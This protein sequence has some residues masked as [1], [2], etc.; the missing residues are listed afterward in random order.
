MKS[1]KTA[2]V[3]PMTEQRVVQLIRAHRSPSGGAG[4][5]VSWNRPVAI[6]V[7]PLAALGIRELSAALLWLFNNMGGGGGPVVDPTIPPCVSPV[8]TTYD[9]QGR[10]EQQTFGSPEIRTVVYSYDAAS[11]LVQKVQTYNGLTRTHTYTYD[12]DNR[13][14]NES[15]VTA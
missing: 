7:P 5:P 3:A 10:I 1:E 6:G 8:A 13:L 11:N 2:D 9:A 14:T 12:A 4:L 15:F